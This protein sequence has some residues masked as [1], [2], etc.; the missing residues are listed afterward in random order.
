MSGKINL[1]IPWSKRSVFRAWG[2]Q[3][4]NEST[5]SLP[6]WCSQFG[7]IKCK[8]VWR[9]FL[10]S[11]HY[12]LDVVC[13]TRC[14]NG[15]YSQMVSLQTCALWGTN[16]AYPT[17]K[18]FRTAKKDSKRSQLPVKCLSHS[19]TEGQSLSS[20]HVSSNLGERSWKLV[21]KTCRIKE[22]IVGIMGFWRCMFWLF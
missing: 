11:M 2:I 7:Q 13:F 15:V 17:G 10:C 5:V 19:L 21:K 18:G 3:K 14:H 22:T 12:G 1:S 9:C 8:H 6:S 16:I 4:I 20:T